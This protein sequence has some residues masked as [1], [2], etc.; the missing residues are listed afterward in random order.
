MKGKILIMLAASLLLT[1]CSQGNKSTSSESATGSSKVSQ[2]SSSSQKASSKSSSVKKSV[3][4]SST[5]ASS[6]SA[7][8]KASGWN[9]TTSNAARLSTFNSEIKKQL[10]SVL[11]P[12]VTGLASD[13]GYLNVRYSGNSSSYKVYYSVG[14]TAKTLNDPSLSGQTPYLVLTKRTYASAS[15][16]QAAVENV[17]SKNNLQGL[18]TTNLGSGITAWTDAGAGQRYVT[19]NEGNWQF[20]VHGAAVNGE[21]AEATAKNLVAL[22]NSYYLPA[23][24]KGKGTFEVSVADGEIPQTLTWAKGSSLY[25]LQAHSTDTL[26]KTAA[27]LK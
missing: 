2:K 6:S 7:S 24:D 19:F 8:S 17:Q 21:D 4:S 9:Q 11:L 20:T 5:S 22:L 1:G 23:P 16:A 25:K 3:S 10:G 15:A 13:S 18:P 12:S 14:Y 27:S 26:I